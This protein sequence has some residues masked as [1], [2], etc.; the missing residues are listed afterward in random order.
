MVYFKT[1]ANLRQ[2]QIEDIRIKLNEVLL[3]DLQV[4][5]DSGNICYYSDD[6]VK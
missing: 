4:V 2:D 5:I 3:E 1:N 6:E